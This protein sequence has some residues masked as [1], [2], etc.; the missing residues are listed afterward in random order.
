[1]FLLLA[2]GV[3]LWASFDIREPDYGQLSPASWPRVIIA[4][5]SLLCFIYLVQSLR[6]GPDPVNEEHPRGPVATLAYW[7]NV[8]WCFVLFLAYL[9]SLPTTRRHCWWRHRARW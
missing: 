9:L 6:Q 5:M 1:V 2:C 4:A 8:L 3:L 7:R